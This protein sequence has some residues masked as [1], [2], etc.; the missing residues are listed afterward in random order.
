MV[1]WL[2]RFYSSL[3]GFT[4]SQAFTE[5]LAVFDV[6][7]STIVAGNRTLQEALEQD[8]QFFGRLS[9]M[10]SLQSMK[11][12]MQQTL[13]MILDSLEA[14]AANN[15]REIIQQICRIVQRD[16]GQALSLNS[17]AEEVFLSPNYLSAIFK[18]I[19]GKNL[20]EYITDVRMENA[21]RMLAKSNMKIHEIA[22]RDGY[23]SPS[24]FGSVFLKRTGLT[25]NQ[26]RINAQ[27]S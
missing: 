12:L 5:T 18:E 3:A 17:L 25:P 27:R 24:Y 23:E 6:L 7:S 11:M 2:N 14:S 1:E 16:Y 19:T 21:R 26:Y 8:A 4:A 9:H 13:S 15:H 10:E 22:H 20:L